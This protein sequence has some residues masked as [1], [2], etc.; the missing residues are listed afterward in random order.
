M[1]IYNER[2]FFARLPHPQVGTQTHTG[3]PWILTNAPQ[4]V[5]SRAPLLGQH[6]DAVLRDVLKYTAEDIARLRARQVLY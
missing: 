2:G 5:R 3:I 4:G 6:T 1:R